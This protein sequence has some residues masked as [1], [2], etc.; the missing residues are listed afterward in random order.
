MTNLVTMFGNIIVMVTVL[1]RG[2]QKVHV[3][4]YVRCA[5]QIAAS[6]VRFNVDETTNI[7]RLHSGNDK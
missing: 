4:A 5:M 1:F 3:R 6:T 7:S 2:I